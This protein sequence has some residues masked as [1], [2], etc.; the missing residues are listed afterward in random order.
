MTPNTATALAASSAIMLSMFQRTPRPSRP[1]PRKAA[2]GLSIPQPH[3]PATHYINPDQRQRLIGQ[4]SNWQRNQAGKACKG[5]WNTL[6]IAD[7]E[8][9]TKLKKG[10]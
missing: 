4:M 2:Q 8:R 9:F 10:A 6:T 3:T 1:S 5:K 7:L